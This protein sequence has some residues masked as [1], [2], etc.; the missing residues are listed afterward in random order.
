MKTLMATDGS[1]QATSAL[2]VA[3]RLLRRTDNEAHVLCVAPEF[4][5]LQNQK[6]W[7]RVRDEYKKR[8]ARETETIL[9][10][11]RKTLLAEGVTAETRAETGSPAKVI[12]QL[13]NDYDVTV[14]G[15]TSQYDTTRPGIGSVASRV[16]EHAPGIVLVCREPRGG[17]SLRILLC[18]DSS[19][20]S[21]QALSAL[22]T[23]LNTESAEVTLMHVVE[24]PWVNL[25]L[26]RD[27]FDQGG[28][29]REQRSSETRLEEEMQSEANEIIQDAVDQLTRHGLD[30]TTVIAEGN[31]ATEILGQAEQD[32]YD[33]IVIGAS[34]ATDMKHRMLGSV[35]ARVTAQAPC[36]V[37]VVK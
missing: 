16:V 3:T 2:R 14:I 10:R 15:A 36:S 28:E 1:H 26:D 33:L 18:V 32:E 17:S 5:E 35:S 21:Q 22:L 37:A 30:V 6:N 23:Y 9:D 4:H 12:V 19:R 20:A 8:I 25:G 27:W 29:T 11:A 34:G 24:T 31:P 7:T 13:A